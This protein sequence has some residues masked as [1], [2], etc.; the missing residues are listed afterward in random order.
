MKLNLNYKEMPALPY[1]QR[2]EL[3]SRHG[4]YYVGDH[5]CSVMY[6]GLARNLKKRHSNHHRQ[7][8]FE[9][10]ENAVIHYKVLPENILAIVTDLTKVLLRLEKQA[11]NYYK[12]TLNDTPVLDK[13]TSIT[14][15]GPIYVQTHV[16]GRAGFCEHFEYQD[17]D[18]LGIN[19]NKLPVLKKALDKQ[20]PIFLIGSGT[21]EE[22][23]LYEY[24]NLSELAPYKNKRIYLLVSRFIPYEYEH[25]NN[26]DS[27]YI[28]YGENSK[29]FISP[30][31]ILND[32]T[33][34]EE[35]RRSYLTSGLINCEQ[36]SFAK[37]LLSLGKFKLLSAT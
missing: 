31:V 4:I 3:P 15:H 9:D 22:Y 7:T 35:F 18:E 25:S 6:V 2:K 34:F 11:K 13:P 36:S 1:S 29:I 21:Y 37:Q 14:V 32:I 26:S 20:R 27:T 17:G 30:Y 12:P 24:P 10:I 23:E 5:T 19:T 33:G 8:Q 16:L 28:L